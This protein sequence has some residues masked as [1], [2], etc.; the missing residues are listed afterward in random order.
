MWYN[1]A[2]A[3]GHTGRAVIINVLQQ[4]L[5]YSRYSRYFVDQDA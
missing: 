3:N 4:S 5:Y 2:V 1:S